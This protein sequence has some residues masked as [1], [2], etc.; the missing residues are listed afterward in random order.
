MNTSTAN[1]EIYKIY[2]KAI[3]WNSGLVFHPACTLEIYSK[4]CP[5]VYFTIFIP[6]KYEDLPTLIRRSSFLFLI[7]FQTVFSLFS[8][9]SDASTYL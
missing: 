9:D 2:Q 4:A 5:V 6:F 1:K 7:Y 8:S 3:H